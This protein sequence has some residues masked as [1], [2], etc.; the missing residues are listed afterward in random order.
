MLMDTKFVG[1]LEKN[2]LEMGL[3]APELARRSGLD[4]GQIYRFISGERQPTPETIV[5]LARGLR[6]PATEVFC[7]V[8]GITASE[9]DPKYSN[10]QGMYE[11]L[12][13]KDRQTIL[14][15]MDFLL[16]K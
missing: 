7:A 6:K 2:M 12:D 4:T 9:K 8:V 10:L 11:A 15:L 13:D 1:Y 5:K 14:N 16:S 3:S